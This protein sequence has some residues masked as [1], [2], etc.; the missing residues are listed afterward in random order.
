MATILKRIGR[1]LCGNL[2][3]LDSAPQMLVNFQRAKP[4]FPVSIYKGIQMQKAIL[5]FTIGIC[6]GVWTTLAH[7]IG[8]F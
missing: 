6:L 2:L 7:L 8:W 4:S 3:V 5:I 1:Q